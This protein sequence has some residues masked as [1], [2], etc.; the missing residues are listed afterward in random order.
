MFEGKLP[1]AV[2]AHDYGIAA[3]SGADGACVNGGVLRELT[4][5]DLRVR[6]QAAR[7]LHD[8]LHGVPDDRLASFD[9]SSARRIA[10]LADSKRAVNPEDL[11]NGK[12]IGCI[13]MTS[14]N[15]VSAATRGNP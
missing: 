14:Q 12:G 4:W 6:L 5:N 1:L 9:A 8:S 13:D 15:V 7:E 10:A 3:D 11:A 2:T